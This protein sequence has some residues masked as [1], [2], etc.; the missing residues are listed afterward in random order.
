MSIVSSVLSVG[1]AQADGRVYVAES[2]TD[3]LGKV[4]RVSYLTAGN[5]DHTAAMNARVANITL[6]LAEVEFL[7]RLTRI[8]ALNL[9]HQTG[10]EFAN[11]VREIYRTAT[12]EIL[13]YVAWWM[14]E[15]IN[16]GFV[17]DAAVRTAFGM[18]VN[19]YNT[20]K[21]TKVVPAHDHWAAVLIAA[22]E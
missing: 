19:A 5:A 1:A 8:G 16:G 10:T 7:D 14:I 3:H 11:R 21:S 20:F 17:T 15:E 13:C 6:N 4:H 2:H 9:Q 18:T 12:K 22:G